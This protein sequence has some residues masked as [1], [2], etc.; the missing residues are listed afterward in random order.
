VRPVVGSPGQGAEVGVEVEVGVRVEDGGNVGGE[1][2][3]GVDSGVSR[4]VHQRLVG[5]VS[6]GGGL[7]VKGR[8]QG[9]G[10]ASLGGRVRRRP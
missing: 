2:P 10:P 9:S 1:G 4:E 3:E 5:S 6:R 8:E 7:M